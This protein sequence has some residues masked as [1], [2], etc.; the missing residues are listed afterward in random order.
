[1][2]GVPKDWGAELR[3]PTKFYQRCLPEV[4][5]YMNLVADTESEVNDFFRNNSRPTTDQ[6]ETT[7][8]Q[9]MTGNWDYGHV[10]F[11]D[12]GFINLIRAEIMKEIN[13]GRE[14]DSAFGYY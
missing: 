1:M 5:R 13:G 6:W 9:A 7:H 10:L 8:S 12:A 14:F 11:T 4:F 2:L 3:P